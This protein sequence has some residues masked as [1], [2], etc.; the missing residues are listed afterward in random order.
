MWDVDGTGIQK[1][2]DPTLAA[3]LFDKVNKANI[4]FGALSAVI[5]AA[6]C[7]FP[8]GQQ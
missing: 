2:D 5:T 7:F 8:I 4:G 1:I 3:A 6:F